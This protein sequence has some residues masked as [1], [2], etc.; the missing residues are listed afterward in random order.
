VPQRELATVVG[1]GLRVRD[2][3]GGWYIVD[4]KGVALTLGG[5]L[6]VWGSFSDAWANRQIP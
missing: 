6:V 1:H 4:A 5:A 3:V 2:V